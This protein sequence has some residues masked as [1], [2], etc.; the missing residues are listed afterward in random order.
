MTVHVTVVQKHE[1]TRYPTN[2]RAREDDTFKFSIYLTA[3]NIS[4]YIITSLM[5]GKSKC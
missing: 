5:C 4:K 1:P 3:P 2:Q